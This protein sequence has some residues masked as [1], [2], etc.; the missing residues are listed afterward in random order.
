MTI[1]ATPVQRVA[2]F[3]VGGDE[4]KPALVVAGF[5]SSARD[6]QEFSKEWSARLQTDGLSY[7]RAVEFAQSVKEFANFKDE[8]R[9]RQLSNDLMG[10]LRRHVYRKFGCIVACKDFNEVVSG[11]LREVFF[12][13]AYVL[14]GMACAADVGLWV[15]RERMQTPPKLFLPRET[16]G[17]AHLLTGYV[18]L[19]TLLPILNA[20]AIGL[21]QAAI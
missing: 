9:R 2:A 19:G 17:K 15:K 6:W 21:T 4:N 8:P 7:F 13:K 16:S 3:D 5:I 11:R 14:G 20:F 1:S 12:P 10:I 18:E